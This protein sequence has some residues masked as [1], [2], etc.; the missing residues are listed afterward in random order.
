MDNFFV[1]LFQACLW[2]LHK[3][4]SRGIIPLLLIMDSSLLAVWVSQVLLVG[5]FAVCGFGLF[6]C[7]VR[8]VLADC[9]RERAPSAFV[10]DVVRTQ[11]ELN[12]VPHSYSPPDQK[13]REKRYAVHYQTTAVAR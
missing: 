5:A 9:G 12:A 11:E 1:F 6:C 10:S 13:Y 7:A 3:Q 8:T 2:I 4:Q